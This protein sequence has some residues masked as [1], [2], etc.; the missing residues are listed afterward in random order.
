MLHRR[1]RC[2]DDDDGDCF[3]CRIKNHPFIYNKTFKKKL[4]SNS[5]NNEKL[6]HK[7]SKGKLLSA[8]IAN[9]KRSRH[10]LRNSQ[11]FNATFLAGGEENGINLN[12]IIKEEIKNEKINEGKIVEK[13]KINIQPNLLQTSI[14]PLTC[15]S[16]IS[17][18]S[19]FPTSFSQNNI[20]T[21]EQRFGIFPFLNGNNNSLNL[22][23]SFLFCQQN[24]NSF[25][26][27]Q[28]PF[29]NE[30][31][32][33]N[34]NFILE[35]NGHTFNEIN[36]QQ[37]KVL[38]EATPNDISSTSL[39]NEI[40]IE[41][42]A[43]ISSEGSCCSPIDHQNNSSPKNSSKFNIDTSS[44]SCSV[45]GDISSGRHY[46]ILACNGCSGFFKR[47]VRRRLI[48]RCQAGTG[49]CI[50]DKA[51]RNQCQACRLK[52]CLSKGM[53]KDAVQNERQPRNSAT[54]HPSN[55]F[56]ILYNNYANFYKTNNSNV[57]SS[58][59]DLVNLNKVQQQNFENSLNIHHP[60]NS[61][62]SS[63]I[64][65]QKNSIPYINLDNL[66][67]KV[68]GRKKCL[69]SI[70]SVKMTGQIKIN[71]NKTSYYWSINLDVKTCFTICKKKV[72]KHYCKKISLL[73][74]TWAELFILFAFENSTSFEDKEIS[75]F[76]PFR[77][78][79]SLNSLNINFKRLELDQNEI[80]WLR[81][82]LLF[83]PD[84][85]ELENVSIIQQLQDQSIVGLQQQTIRRLP[86]I[87]R[88]G[89]ILLFLPALRLVAEPRLSELVFIRPTF[90]NKPVTKII[91]NLMM[92]KCFTIVNF[93]ML[94]FKIV[95]QLFETILQF[96][97]KRL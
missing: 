69:H 76:L 56:D 31:Q 54:I 24:N 39:S 20:P 38:I 68:D 74:N 80:S 43:L 57:L 4:E 32:N 35:K 50:V 96:V 33:K 64:F 90:E 66:L 45:C 3:G 2:V 10:S 85:P 9:T 77:L 88:F 1:N 95:L 25:Q 59:I 19:L 16:S 60:L 73:E 36:K 13:Q 21:T 8:L 55:D 81:S 28:Q 65:N 51:H 15:S 61:S 17:S 11:P 97:V 27:I 29:I 89:R 49:N 63:L 42:A 5:L 87:T 48:Y 18:S 78:L 37:N 93:M 52:K 58:A 41:S 44:L 67:N 53:N 91:K 46:G 30:N 86:P 34:N 71:K 23:N 82:V 47:S 84:I 72:V 12:N 79:Q 7:T 94:M 83:R 75:K 22:F 6:Y 70:T 26:N 40:S 14:T 62:S 92:F